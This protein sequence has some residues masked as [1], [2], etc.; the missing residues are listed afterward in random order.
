MV[1]YIGKMKGN[2]TV[3]WPLIR[4]FFFNFYFFNFFFNR[5][6]SFIRRGG[7]GTYI[8]ADKERGLRSISP[9][10]APEKFTPWDARAGKWA[11]RVHARCNATHGPTNKVDRGLRLRAAARLIPVARGLLGLTRVA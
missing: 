10:R 2:L 6:G 5:F 3:G 7:G 4:D 11:Q 9:A 8:Q 1:S